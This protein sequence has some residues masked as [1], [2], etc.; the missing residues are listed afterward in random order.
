MISDEAIIT[1]PDDLPPMQIST[2]ESNLD[3]WR[4][5]MLIPTSRKDIRYMLN[6]KVTVVS[7]DELLNYNNIDELLHPY[8]S[9][10]ILYPNPPSSALNLDDQMG[11]WCCLFASNSGRLFFYDSYGCYID[12]KIKDYDEA[13]DRMHEPHKLEPKLLDLILNSEY[14]DKVNFSEFP[15]QS[16][17]IDTAVCGLYCVFRL[18]NKHFSESEFYNIFHE[19]PASEG[20]LPDLAIAGLTCKLFP[21][22]CV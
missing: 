21:E 13:M 6:D 11:H 1:V 16:E 10:V 15:M 2:Q 3:K 20:V 22:M 5:R 12:S 7:F 4:R 19:L 14:A 18:K 8:M 17:T 9:V